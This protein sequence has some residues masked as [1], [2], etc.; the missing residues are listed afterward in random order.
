MVFLVSIEY[1]TNGIM[2]YTASQLKRHLLTSPFPI[3]ITFSIGLRPCILLKCQMLLF[4]NPAPV[5]VSMHGKSGY[6]GSLFALLFKC[7][8]AYADSSGAW[9]SRCVRWKY[10]VRG[11][12]GRKS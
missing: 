7:T 1:P 10:L 3:F 11:G 8:S 9:E 12:G 6:V 5:C 2:D 4:I